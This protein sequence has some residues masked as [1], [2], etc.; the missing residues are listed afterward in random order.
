MFYNLSKGNIC[1]TRQESKDIKRDK[2]TRG[3]KAQRMSYILTKER[4]KKEKIET[5]TN[6]KTYIS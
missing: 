5:E 4:E 1:C 3:E 6:N 2:R